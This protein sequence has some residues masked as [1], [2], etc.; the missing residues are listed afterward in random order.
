MDKIDV[1]NIAIIGLGEIGSRHLQALSNI[2]LPCKIYGVDPSKI[3]LSVAKSRLEEFSVNQ[4]PDTHFL[5][6]VEKLPKQL[7][8]VIIATSSDI[9]LKDSS[10]LK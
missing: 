10:L 1:K 9:R 4:D 2:T 7:G 3:A 6:S 8:L 5:H